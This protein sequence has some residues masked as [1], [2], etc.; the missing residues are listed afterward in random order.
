[1]RAHPRRFL[2][3]VPAVFIVSI[4]VGLVFAKASLS[5]AIAVQLFLQT[6]GLLGLYLPVYGK[7]RGGDG[8]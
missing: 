8:G 7:G 5:L 1:M 3:G 2:W 6:V 4:G